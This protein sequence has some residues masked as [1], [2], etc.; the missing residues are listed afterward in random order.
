MSVAPKLHV[1]EDHFYSQLSLFKGLGDYSEDFVEQAHQ[2]GM[3]EEARTFTMKDQHRIA[4]IHCWNKHKRSLPTVKQIQAAVA[5]KASQNRKQPQVIT[6]KERQKVERSNKC[7]PTL[8]KIENEN[9]I[10][11]S[12]RRLNKDK[13]RANHDEANSSN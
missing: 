11:K 1:L 2:I 5:E 9:E 3:R 4:Q 12:G 13:A 7:I 8:N 6:A 10:Y